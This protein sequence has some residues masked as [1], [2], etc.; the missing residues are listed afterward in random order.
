[1]GAEQ[2]D[3]GILCSAPYTWAAVGETRPSPSEL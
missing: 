2:K 1:M 3:P